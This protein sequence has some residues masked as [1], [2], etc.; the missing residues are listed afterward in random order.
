MNHASGMGVSDGLADD[1]K[2]IEQ[3]GKLNWVS[4]S[5]G[6][7]L[8]VGLSGLAEG[9]SLHQAHRIKG[10]PRI[11][12]A[13]QLVNRDDARMLQLPG[14]LR[15]AKE[16]G[17]EHSVI[18]LLGPK[19]LQRHITAHLAVSGH[20]DPANPSRRVQLGERITILTRGSPGDARC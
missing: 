4:L 6:P 2:S 3:G 12:S 20:P 14:D 16:A 10:P 1:H 17:A 18:R 19:F 7:L 9:A 15:L 5:R 8:V 11:R 13:S